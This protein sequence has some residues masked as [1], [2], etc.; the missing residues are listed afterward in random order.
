MRHVLPLLLMMSFA[1]RLS[2]QV[3][4]NRGDVLAAFD[5]TI[6]AYDRNGAYKG[7][8]INMP[9]RTLS[10]L[11]YRDGIIYVGARD[12]DAIERV[13]AVSGT[14]LTPFNLGFVYAINY[15]SPG[16]GG[17]LLAVNGSGEIYRFAADGSLV[18]L[19]TSPASPPA[20]H[21]IDLAADG[22]S[23]FFVT[24]T[25][26]ARWDACVNAPA[27]VIVDYGLGGVFEHLRLLPDGTF[28]VSRNGAQPILHIDSAGNILRQYSLFGPGI[29]LD[30]DGTS[31]WTTF[32]CQLRRV[33]IASGAVLAS[34]PCFGAGALAVVGEPRAGLPALHLGSDVP[35]VSTIVLA[36]LAFSLAVTAVL[37][38]R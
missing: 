5:S 29:A 17:G 10:D 34:S 19:R 13:D 26:V 15:L 22:C 33:D 27:V 6:V 21:G 14:L 9:G 31:F 36:L 4:L 1:A 32:G 18:F 16:P 3:V 30:I 12:P 25:R 8:I 24:S 37:K 2:A 28:L 38:L 23:A 35:A 20:G 7:Q 11:F